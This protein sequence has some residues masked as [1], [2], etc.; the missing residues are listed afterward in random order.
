MDPRE[1]GAVPI[2]HKYHEGYKDITNVDLITQ[3][4]AEP[5]QDTWQNED[6]LSPH[7]IMLKI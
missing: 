3:R 5:V 1:D 6:A 4:Q 2:W 7:H